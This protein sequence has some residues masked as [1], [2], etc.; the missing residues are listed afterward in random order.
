MVCICWASPKVFADAAAVV[1]VE[2]TAAAMPRTTAAWRHPLRMLITIGSLLFASTAVRCPA[3]C[4]REIVGD[5]VPCGVGVAQLRTVD[6]DRGA[7]AVVVVLT[8][9]GVLPGEAAHVRPGRGLDRRGKFGVA[10]QD[11]GDGVGIAP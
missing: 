10:D 2:T 3:V 6:G 1:V 11:L 4:S 8:E 9:A 5:R 7:R